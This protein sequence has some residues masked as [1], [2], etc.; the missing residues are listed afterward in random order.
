MRRNSHRERISSERDMGG[1]FEKFL[2]VGEGAFLFHQKD[3]GVGEYG[4]RGELVGMV[5]DQSLVPHPLR[6]KKLEQVETEVLSANSMG[7]IQ[8]NAPR[9]AAMRIRLLADEG[10]EAVEHDPSMMDLLC[11]SREEAGLDQ[12]L[13]ELGL[14]PVDWAPNMR[15]GRRVEA[16]QKLPPQNLSEAEALE[17]QRVIEAAFEQNF[18]YS[19]FL[20]GADLSAPMS[21]FVNQKRE[22]HCEYFAGASTL[23][24][25][26]MGIPSRYVVGFVVRETGDDENEYMLRGKHAHAWSQ[27]YVGGRW[28]DESKPGASQALWR[29]RGGKW[30][31]VDLTP[32]DW[33][34]G[35]DREP[36]YQMISDWFQ[37]AKCHLVLW[38]SRP[39]VV[40]GFKVILILLGALLL[41]YLSY[42]MLKNRGREGGGPLGDWE[43]EIRKQ[44][45]LREFERWLARRVGPRP[46]ALPMGVWLRENLP[47]QGVGL[48]QRYE[49]VTYGAR[50]GDVG[51]K[52]VELEELGA[53]I[54]AAKKLW[55][56]REEEQRKS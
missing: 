29:C 5:S 31:T 12:F 50:G 21:E 43:L 55:R 9:Q 56:L 49:A 35:N 1:D 34:A 40:A 20:T 8:L 30:V 32:G 51:A 46:S 14:S 4:M 47:D 27:A 23:L 53:A 41:I 7:A 15:K 13:E 39:S 26:R 28:V 22:G 11:P 37:K 10:L 17:V 33:L 54:T 42:K 52:S 36:W 16:S 2:E 18:Q 19:L 24:L 45:Y 44:G 38:F 6:T 3:L 25:R 48:V